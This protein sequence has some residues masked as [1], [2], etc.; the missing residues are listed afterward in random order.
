[1]EK[2]YEMYCPVHGKLTIKVEKAPLIR[3]RTLYCPL[4]ANRLTES[5]LVPPV[6]SN[7]LKNAFAL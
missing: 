7:A 2:T 4:C 6:G 5:E 3:S 1:M